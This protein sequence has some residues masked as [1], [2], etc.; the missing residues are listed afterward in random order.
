MAGPEAGVQRRMV[1]EA[2]QA[3]PPKRS[4]RVPL[5]L[6]YHCRGFDL[7]FGAILDESADNEN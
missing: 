7:N 1:R 2:G 5:S 4:C 3:I 6:W